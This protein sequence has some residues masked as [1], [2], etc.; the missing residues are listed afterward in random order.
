VRADEGRDADWRVAVVVLASLFTVC[1]A[2][3]AGGGGTPGPGGLVA[4]ALALLPAALAARSRGVVGL[5][6][7]T[8]VSQA[9]GHVVL[10]VVT[11]PAGGG[12]AVHTG[13]PAPSS[14]AVAGCHDAPALPAA[15]AT[16]GGDWSHTLGAFGHLA[17]MGPAMLAAHA[18][19]VVLTAALVGAVT[20]AFARV[21]RRFVALLRTILLPSTP[22][23]PRCPWASAVRVVDAPLLAA[24]PLR[25]PPVRS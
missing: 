5:A 25:G 1:A 9:V 4:L 6:A 22:H 23:V 14:T 2:H 10:G 18:T 7:A 17:H 15:P 21:A 20:T 16:D 8:A 13:H 12:P 3:A 24:H 11:L 19:A